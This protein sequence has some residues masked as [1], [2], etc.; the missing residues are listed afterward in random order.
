MVHNLIKYILLNYFSVVDVVT[1]TAR[2][3]KQNTKA[4]KFHFQVQTSQLS[5][6]IGRASEN[7]HLSKII[8]LSIIS[9]VFPG[10]FTVP[11]EGGC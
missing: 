3:P 11:E 9:V 7:A 6:H 8:C 4:P 10:L 1:V 2:N 5:S